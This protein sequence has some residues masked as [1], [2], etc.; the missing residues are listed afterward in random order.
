MTSLVTVELEKELIPSNRCSQ[1]SMYNLSSLQGQK[2]WVDTIVIAAIYQRVHIIMV[3][4]DTIPLLDTVTTLQR[5]HRL[6]EGRDWIVVA[7]DSVRE[8]PIGGGWRVMMLYL[9]VKLVARTPRRDAANV[10]K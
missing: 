10:T 1:F 4:V 2:N 8:V 9:D 5:F 6:R 3:V 7:R